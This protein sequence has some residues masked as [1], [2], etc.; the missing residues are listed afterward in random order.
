MHEPGKWNS[1]LS[2]FWLVCLTSTKRD[3]QFEKGKHVYF[4][5]LGFIWKLKSRENCNVTILIQFQIPSMT[6]KD[7]CNLSGQICLPNWK[8]T[9]ELL[10]QGL[11]FASLVVLMPPHMQVWFL[12]VMS[13]TSML[14]WSLQL[15]LCASLGWLW[16]L[17]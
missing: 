8:E 10:G 16:W 12:Q 14:V 1:L 13:C 11:S 3:G 7:F 9:T 15:R 17:E 6:H 5:T 4:S 2:V